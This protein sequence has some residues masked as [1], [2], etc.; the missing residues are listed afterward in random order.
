MSKKVKRAARKSLKETATSIRSGIA[1]GK[2]VICNTN[3]G[4]PMD[5]A[6]GIVA[7][8]VIG[9]IVLTAVNKLFNTNIMPNV[10]NFISDMFKIS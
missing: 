5:V 10:T 2:E 7:T 8:V 4:G 9:L 1:K 3:G 6:Y